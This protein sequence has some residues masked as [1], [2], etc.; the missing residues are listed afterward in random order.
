MKKTAAQLN[1]E[2]AEALAGSSPVTI[3][4]YPSEDEGAEETEEQYTV[5]DDGGEFDDTSAMSA[6][7]VQGDIGRAPPLLPQDRTERRARHSHRKGLDLTHETF[8]RYAS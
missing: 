2:I 1:R 6:P 7:D 4:V 5:S 3:S 8:E